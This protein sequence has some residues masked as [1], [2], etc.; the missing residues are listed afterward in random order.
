[1]TLPSKRVAILSA[2][3]VLAL[4]AGAYLATR[5][6]AVET[7]FDRLGGPGPNSNTS[8]LDTLFEIPA[9]QWP[10]VAQILGAFAA[11]HGWSVQQGAGDN[12]PDYRWLDMCDTAVTIVRASNQH[13]GGARRIGF[14]IIH[15]AYDGPANDGWRPF[16]RDL[17]RRFEARWP[18]RMRYVDGEFRRPT[19]RPAWLDREE[20]VEADVARPGPGN[21]GAE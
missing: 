13:E 15:M 1:M 12:D 17:H 19:G 11:E 16:Y 21:S 4:V 7:C 2:A 3:G 5:P 8:R 20:A 10:A 14:G 9:D 6:P 18:G